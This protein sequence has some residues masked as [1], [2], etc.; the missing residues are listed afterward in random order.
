MHPVHTDSSGLE[1]SRCRRF[2]LQTRF[3]SPIER[4][5]LQIFCFHRKF[6]RSLVNDP[7]S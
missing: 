1:A 7:A 5:F 6:T 2:H 4:E 3:L